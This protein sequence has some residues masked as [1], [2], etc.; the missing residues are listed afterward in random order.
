MTSA[1]K[2]RLVALPIALA[3]VA[4]LSYAGSQGGAV[5]GA[6]PLFS[7]CAL[8]SLVIQWVAF[9]PAYLMR[10]ER[11]YDL[12]GSLTYLT[13][14]VVAIGLGPPADTRS[15]LLG[16]LVA[17]WAARL[18]AFLFGRIRRSGSD[19]RFDEIKTSFVRFFVAWTLQGVWVCFT[20]GAALAAMAS[21]RSVPL[22]TLEWVGLALWIAGFGIEVVADRQKSRFRAHAENEGQFI[23]SGLWAWSRHPNYFGEIVLWT[24]IALIAAP[25]LQG[26]QYVTLVSPVFVTFLL[27]KVSGIPL[28]EARADAKWGGD[29]R[30][31]RYKAS[32]PVLVPRPP[33]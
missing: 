14:T 11:F 4:G 28:L 33:R 6:V 8:L 2:K 29:Q 15:G 7:L 10:T 13:A 25:V 5:V 32:T 17:V 20:M 1:E 22:G 19:R 26:W 18:G 23:D 21:P 30:Y 16:V 9:V 31:E 24:G 3:A 12:T 27:T